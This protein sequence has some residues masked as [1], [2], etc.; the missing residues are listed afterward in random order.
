MTT[1]LIARH[2]NTFGPG[3]TPLRV[4]KR[5]DLPLVE[6]GREQA[7]RIGLWMK[8]RALTPQAVFTS[9]LKRTIETARLALDMAGLETTTRTILHLFDEIDHGPDEGKTEEDV[10]ARLGPQALRLWDE[11]ATMPQDWTPRPEA[12]LSGW[13]EFLETIRQDFPDGLVL[14]VTSNGVA[15]F[16]PFLATPDEKTRRPLKLSTGALGQMECEDNS[17]WTV[18]FWN[19]RPSR[20]DP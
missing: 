10:L 2:G 20:P 3:E 18:S 4:G 9:S 19:V 7:R 13:K 6:S 12:I 14:V 1:L 16:A 11:T 8:E 15:R 5:T 17:S